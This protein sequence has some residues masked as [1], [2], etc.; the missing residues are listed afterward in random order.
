M[1]KIALFKSGAI[2][3]EEKIK[4]KDIGEEETKLIVN[5]VRNK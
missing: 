2:K 5:L 1:A 3:K 4:D